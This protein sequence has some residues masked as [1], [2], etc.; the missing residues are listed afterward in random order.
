MLIE[1]MTQ[2]IRYIRGIRGQW[3]Q[4][5]ESAGRGRV[6]AEAGRVKLEKHQ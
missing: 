5:G 3:G 2:C 4:R 6:N 1:Q